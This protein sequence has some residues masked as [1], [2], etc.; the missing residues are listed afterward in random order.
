MASS[1][2]APTASPGAGLGGLAIA[3]GALFI[4]PFAF[5][6]QRNAE[7]GV[8][9]FDEVAARTTL[10]PLGRSLLLGVT[11]SGT[12]AV[13]GTAFAWLTTRTDLPFRRVWRVL[14]PLPLVFPSFV[15]ATAL[16]A[17]FASG[18][19][20][21][22]LLAPLGDFDLPNIRG[23]R[24][25][26]LVL[27]VFTYPYVYLPV[28]ARLGSLPPSLD[29]SAR[30]LGRSPWGV[31]RAVVLPQAKGAI[32][33]GSLLVFLYAISDFGAVALLGYD[34]LT[35]Q[36]YADR[37][38]DQARSMALA[39]LLALT[40][41]GVVVL[42]RRMRGQ[43]D[44]AQTVSSV[45]LAPVPL[46]RW[47]WPAVFGVVTVVGN[48]LIGPVAILGFW[49]WRGMTSD[50]ASIGR[51]FDAGA[52]VGPAIRTALIALVT[53]VV[54]ILAVLP[55]AWLTARYRS[56]VGE[57][58]NALVVAGFAIPGVVIALSIVFW[59]LEAP[60][61]SS[62]YQ[63][64]PLLVLAYVLHFGAQATRASQVAVAA[65]PLRLSDAGRTLGATRFRRLLAIELP[66]M[67]PGLVAGAGLV[68]LSTMKELPATLLLA[69]IGFD[70]LATN[71]WSATEAGAL[72][73][74]GLGSL[75]LVALSGVLTWLV[76]LRQISHY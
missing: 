69:P 49:A 47:R 38:F 44:T 59:V 20:I 40:T 45:E 41:V 26:W 53:A 18:G 19:L 65:V 30:L 60:L 29:E 61:V 2:N 31:F 43:L 57:I 67:R 71:I 58:A 16:I 39:L 68:L 28:A 32:W 4:A 9:L 13:V 8:D 51:S 63:T 11:V 52:L 34:T 12:A 3:I 75:V 36:I 50:V 76:V 55:I 17:G 23:F 6:I 1:S 54:A 5:V 15:G 72:A 46:G 33:A 73:Q 70:T 25:A 42:E 14:A 48:A 21:E 7:L 74:A 22:Q 62:L 24:G 37:L 35:E 64:L 10:D 27:T 56:R 66:L